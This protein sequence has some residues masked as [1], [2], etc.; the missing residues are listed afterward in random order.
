MMDKLREIISL[1]ETRYSSPPSLPYG[2]YHD[3][4]ETSVFSSNEVCIKKHNINLDIY[5]KN[6]DKNLLKQVEDILKRENID[7]NRDE[8]E[9][10]TNEKLYV[11][12]YD[13]FY[14]EKGEI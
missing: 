5:M 8:I 7:F 4:I 13:F 14:F 2:V 9:W 12:Y 1:K 11:A 6:I 10:L 3:N